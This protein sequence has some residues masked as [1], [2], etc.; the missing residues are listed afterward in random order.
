MGS[1]HVISFPRIINSRSGSTLLDERIN[2]NSYSNILIEQ[3][4]NALLGIAF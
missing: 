4:S 1:A 3:F 2:V